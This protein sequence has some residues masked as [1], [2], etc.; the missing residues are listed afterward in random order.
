MFFKYIVIFYRAPVPFIYKETRERS[1]IL[2]DMQSVIIR[3]LDELFQPFDLYPARPDSPQTDAYLGSNWIPVVQTQLCISC[4]SPFLPCVLCLVFGE[5]CRVVEFDPSQN[6]LRC[7]V[8]A[9]LSSR[10]IQQ[11]REATLCWLDLSDHLAA[12]THR[13]THLVQ[14]RKSKSL[15][16]KMCF[17]FLKSTEN[18]TIYHIPYTKHVRVKQKS[19]YSHIFKFFR[20]WK[21]QSQWYWLWDTQT[22]LGVSQGPL[23]S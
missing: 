4:S 1:A 13:H 14:Q 23:S 5:I 15:P 10:A 19:R 7:T 6:K 17:W 11:L 3:N 18:F 9:V 21:Q 20:C 16:K 8:L 12:H 22:P 2:F